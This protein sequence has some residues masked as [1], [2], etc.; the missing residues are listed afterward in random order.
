M[1]KIITVNTI[2]DER[3]SLGV[4]EKEL[5]FTLKRVFYIYDVKGESKRG[6][7]GHFKTQ[8]CLICLNGSCLVNVSNQ[9]EGSSQFQLDSPS[10]MLFL[11]PSDWHEMENF[12]PGSVLLVLA[13]EGYDSEDYFFERP[14]V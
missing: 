4:I 3:G 7:H 11:N 14:I 6:G 8:M 2:T 13:S 5:P 10:K 1:A 9:L 12:S